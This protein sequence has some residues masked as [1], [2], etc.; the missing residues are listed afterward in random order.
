MYT[1]VKN[2]QLKKGLSAPKSLLLSVEGQVSLLKYLIH[3]DY[4]A[5]YYPLRLQ[6]I[7][8]KQGS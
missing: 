1:A 7:A 8:F 6:Q 5:H 3:V 2:R 4:A